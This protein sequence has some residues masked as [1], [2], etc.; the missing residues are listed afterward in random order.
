VLSCTIELVSARYAKIPC[1]LTGRH[2]RT[3][4][5]RTKVQLTSARKAPTAKSFFHEKA[6]VSQDGF[7]FLIL[8]GGYEPIRLRRHAD[9]DTRLREIFSLGASWAFSFQQLLP[10]RNRCR[11]SDIPGILLTRVRTAPECQKNSHRAPVPVTPIRTRRQPA[12]SQVII[13]SNGIMFNVRN[14]PISLF[15][16]RRP[17]QPQRSQPAPNPRP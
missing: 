12:Y 1:S 10:P 7:V 17:P 5:S 16:D 3:K 6:G 11:R 13:N 14:Q 9:I 4:S 2:W 8:S 15:G